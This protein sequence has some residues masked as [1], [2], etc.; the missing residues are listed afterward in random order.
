T[1]L[2]GY[3]CAAPPAGSSAPILCEAR[4]SQ[5]LPPFYFEIDW[6]IAAESGERTVTGI[7]IRRQGEAEPFQ[8]ISDVG[9]SVKPTTDNNGF[10]VS[11]LDL[12]VHLDLRLL[13]DS[14]AVPNALFRSWLWS[15][16]DMRFIYHGMLDDIV[17]LDFAP[18][19]QGFMC[20]W[21]V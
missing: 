7:A 6:Q 15:W 1:F 8:T 5:L 3:S 17:S 18:E 2:A 19:T 4:I 10:E 12:V 9:S 21:R 14:T 16:R 11:D 20:R 13:A